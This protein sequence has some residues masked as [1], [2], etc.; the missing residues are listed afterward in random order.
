M[1]CL[2]LAALPASAS[3]HE[4]EVRVSLP[5]GISPDAVTLVW[6]EVLRSVTERDAPRRFEVKT[7]VPGSTKVDLEAGGVWRLG[8][9]SNEFWAVPEIV[10]VEETPMR[11]ELKL[12]PATSLTGRIEVERGNKLPV[13]LDLRFNSSPG[14]AFEIGRAVTS[15][16][17]S[18]GRFECW[19]PA[20]SLDLRLRAAGFV[21]RYFW[22][23][24][25]QLADARDLGTTKLIRGGS[26]VGWIE[27]EDR[28]AAFEEAL[29]LLTG[30]VASVGF[31]AST[32]SRRA[33]LVQEATVNSRGFF[34][35]I[36]IAEGQYAIT[37]AHPRFALARH[38]PIHVSMNAE[39]ELFP[40]EL[41]QGVSLRVVVRPPR[42]VSEKPW[43]LELLRRGEAPGHLETVAQGKADRA[44]H[45]MP[46]SL[47]PDDYVLQVRDG[48]D[49]LWHTEEL[50]L[51]ASV[52]PI[53]YPVDL[54]AEKLTGRIW[55]GDEP[56]R[57]ELYF[58][59]Y[60]GSLRIPAWSDENGNFEVRAP[61]RESWSV[62]VYARAE[63][64]AQRF[65][66]VVPEP[67]GDGQA[68]V[69]LVVPDTLL[70]GTVVDSQDR[71]VESARVTAAG[72]PSGG[73][74]QYSDEE[75]AFT[76]RGLRHGSFWLKAESKDRRLKSRILKLELEPEEG[77]EPVELVLGPGRLVQGQVI[78]PSGRGIIGAKVIGL[79]E[80]T[81]E[82]PIENVV[83]EALT[84]LNGTF[85]LELPELTEGL[86][87][88]VFPP[89]FATRQI[90]V[91]SRSP[92]PVL[93]RVEAHGGT[94]EV[95]H[96]ALERYRVRVYSTFSLPFYP[97]LVN[98]AEL[99]GET[100]DFG[101]RLTL[102]MLEPGHYYACKD[103]GFE[104][105]MTGRLPQ[106]GGAR[107]VG[108][109]LSPY[110]ELSLVLD[111][112]S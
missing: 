16:P 85:S 103:P 54:A 76:M 58:G 21:S 48:P 49:A 72:G 87:L 100:N 7:Q 28:E 31:D 15:C 97:Y 44:G 96:G 33:G 78:G 65:Q 50:R 104:S 39:T 24:D 5:A 18:E 4:I 57:A 26:I 23:V 83:P 1:G 43:E 11:V 29:V 62:D 95:Q 86:Q 42:P 45:W 77:P 22:G 105:Q 9:S 8:I 68:W 108:G 111:D 14:N 80:Q 106:G 40:I 55:L 63:K 94:L 59:G 27:M 12:L 6:S 60:H 52:E 2:A 92:G 82:Q 70:E 71:P 75:G 37:V 89:G 53:E 10:K 56:L 61:V 36:G 73:Q 91:D 112:A 110:G 34:E 47:P 30:Q 25:P 74:T 101:D 41:Q 99:N 90:R 51:L 20:S 88:T 81:S 67:S 3:A 32:A 107:C 79:I 109:Q 66:D 38:A 19:V 84:D 93:I 64:V 102:P 46:V 69:E 35:F 98:W 17:V 13:E